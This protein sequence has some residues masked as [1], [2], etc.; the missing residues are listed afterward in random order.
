MQINIQSTRGMCV[1][2]SFLHCL[3]HTLMVH[4]YIT[5]CKPS[6]YSLNTLSNSSLYKNI[7]LYVVYVYSSALSMYEFS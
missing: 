1:Y 4:A 6:L 3:L 7:L 5:L 2:R